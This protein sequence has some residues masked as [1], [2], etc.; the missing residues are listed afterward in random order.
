MHSRGRE[1]LLLC[2]LSESSEIETRFR[3]F[4][5]Y[6][7]LSVSHIQV[8]ICPWYLAD[9]NFVVDKHLVVKPSNTI[10]VTGLRRSTRSSDL[11]RMVNAEFGNVFYA[12]INIDRELKYPLGEGMGSG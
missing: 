3:H 6:L 12:R 5:V 8:E 10:V 1:T 4:H 9:S 11:A 7:F 2:L